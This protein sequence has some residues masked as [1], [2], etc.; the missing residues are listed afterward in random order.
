MF[1]SL[2][3]ITKHDET[4]T[5]KERIME[6]LA[7]AVLSVALFGALYLAIHFLG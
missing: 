6:G 7:I 2:E 1:E 5:R 4:I 3:Q